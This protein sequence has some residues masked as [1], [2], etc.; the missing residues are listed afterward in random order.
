MADVDA[1][2]L[3]A[4]PDEAVAGGARIRRRKWLRWAVVAVALTITAAMCAT[5]GLS[6]WEVEARVAE[7]VR[8]H[9][10]SSRRELQ[11]AIADAFADSAAEYRGADGAPFSRV[12][13]SG[14]AGEPVVRRVG[15]DGTVRV[16][17]VYAEA[18]LIATGWG[19]MYCLVID[20]PVEGATH[21]ARVEGDFTR[22]DPCAH[23]QT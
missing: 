13:D 20:V 2:A 23:A 22:P 21:R 19:D 7:V 14:I 17:I 9:P 8:S 5:R 11:R 3:N 12:R 10:D 15:E 16:A 4:H 1:T 6:P 18:P